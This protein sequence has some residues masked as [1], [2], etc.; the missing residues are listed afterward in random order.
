MTAACSNADRVSIQNLLNAEVELPE[1]E[2][3][4]SVTGNQSGHSTV[5]EEVTTKEKRNNR[6][7]WTKE[8]DSLLESLV[9]RFGAGG[10]KILAKYFDDRSSSQLRARWSHSLRCKDSKRPFS[11]QEDDYILRM[12][13]RYGN[14]WSLI[15]KEMSNRSDNSTKNRFRALQNRERRVKPNQSTV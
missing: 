6:R 9:M 5:K 2:A 4:E 13:Q 12:H 8:E 1:L 7:L 11:V 14:K 10:W 15:A 3:K